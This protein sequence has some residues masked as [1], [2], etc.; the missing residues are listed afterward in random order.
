[1]QA[2]PAASECCKNY[3][4]FLE[5]IIQETTSN[6]KG[7]G[8]ASSAATIEVFRNQSLAEF[9]T[10]AFMHSI[11]KMITPEVIFRIGNKRYAAVN[12]GSLDSMLRATVLTGTGNIGGNGAICDQMRAI[13]P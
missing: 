12:K 7:K 11:T 5:I 13:D 6:G 9:G 4:I 3:Q 10:N 8:K 1:M 2:T